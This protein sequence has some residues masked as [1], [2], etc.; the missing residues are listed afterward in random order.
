[1]VQWLVDGLHS[2]SR[3]MSHSDLQAQ[4]STEKESAR[5]TQE[6]LEKERQNQ[7]KISLR[8]SQEEHQKALLR[9]DFQ[10]QS[11]GLQARLQQ[12]LWSQERTLLVQ[13]SQHLKQALL[14]LSL[15][16]RCFLKHAVSSTLAD[17][18]VALQDLSAEL[19][20]ERQGS[21]ELTQQFAKAKASWE[22]ERTELKSLIMQV[23][24]LLQIVY[25]YGD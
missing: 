24:K 9:R 17:L 2:L 23:T 11:L 6:E 14:L 21:Q 15:K 20:Q 25:V 13:E 19:R 1:M 18:K 10:L 22:V 12:R 7:K 3:L 4:L 5:G 16:L 8:L